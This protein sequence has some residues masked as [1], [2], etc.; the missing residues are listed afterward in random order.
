MSSPYDRLSHDVGIK[1]IAPE[2]SD[3]VRVPT[4]ESWAL[5]SEIVISLVQKNNRHR[6]WESIPKLSVTPPRTLVMLGGKAIMP[7]YPG[8]IELPASYNLDLPI[9]TGSSSSIVKESQKLYLIAFVAEVGEDQDPI[10]GQVTFQYKEIDTDAITTIQKE[11][12]RRYRVFWLYVLSRT[13]VTPQ[14]IYES[15]ALDADG[16]RRLTINT[17][18]S[19]GFTVGTLTFYA[20]DPNLADGKSYA[21]IS[22]SLDTIPAF[23]IRRYQNYTERGYTYG[24]NG[25]SALDKDINIGFI[26]NLVGL[27]DLDTQIWQRLN[28]EIFAGNPGKGSVFGRT[29]Q[30]LTSGPVGGNPGYAGEA[31]ASPNGSVA[32]ANEQRISFTNQATLSRFAARS[33]QATNDGNGNALVI[34]VLNSAPSG[35][36]FSERA[37]AHQV[38]APDGTDITSLGRFQNLGGVGA[39]NWIGGPNAGTYLLPGQTCI[40]CPGIEYPAG[41]GFNIPFIETEKVWVGGVEIHPDNIRNAGEDLA[42]YEAPANSELYIAILGKERIALHYIYVHCTLTTNPQGILMIPGNARGKIAFIQGVSGRVDKPIISGLSP[43]TNYNCLLYYAPSAAEAW[44]FQFKYPFYEGSSNNDQL[45][46]NGAEIISKPQFF[47]H[48][49][50]GGQSVFQGDGLLRFSPIAMHLPASSNITP[51]YAF[52]SPIQLM[53]E[54]Y[55]GPLTFREMPLLSGAGTIMPSPGQIVTTAATNNLQARGL[56][57]SLSVGGLPI[58]F[59]SPILNN[60]SPFQSVFGFAVRK[61]GVTKLCILTRNGI[62]GETIIANADLGVGIDVYQL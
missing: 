45:W 50:G 31:A 38:F 28:Q 15:I 52:N 62:G 24:Y 12:D 9:L 58:G 49:Q 41:S 25:E 36:R 47:I 17:K 21:V 33:I 46:L 23:E 30:N 22:N 56:R 60:R 54:S 39:L 55:L 1:P 13:E 11:N 59:R 48:T 34:Y 20:F 19:T 8:T 26:G 3:D 16:V 44:Q 43:N 35:T 7:T 32:I 27:T 57:L 29:I 14:Q 53:G 6:G 4:A 51:S 37:S 18:S 40:F 2:N 42:A 5:Q 61:N 10:L